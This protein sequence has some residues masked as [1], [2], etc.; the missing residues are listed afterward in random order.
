MAKRTT[1]TGA[2]IKSRVL[3]NIREA[4]IQTADGTLYAV[5][6]KLASETHP[7]E[8][9]TV[10]IV[11]RIDRE[12]E[13]LRLGAVL[14]FAPRARIVIET[15]PDA[16]MPE[17]FPAFFALLHPTLANSFGGKYPAEYWQIHEGRKT[18]ERQAFEIAAGTA[19]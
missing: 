11:G 7:D 19:K 1:I 3:H 17:S 15:A 9:D 18:T 12:T 14:I 2:V 6:P 16:P 10:T 5:A 4:I 8:G 13:Y